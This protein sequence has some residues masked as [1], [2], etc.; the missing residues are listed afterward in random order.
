MR[1]VDFIQD[2]FFSLP[3]Y[4]PEKEDYKLFVFKMLD[5]FLTK[6]N[7]IDRFDDIH[8]SINSIRERQ[9]HLVK[10]LKQA[11]DDYYD[12]KPAEAFKKLANGLNSNVKN[13]SDLLRIRKF[14]TESDFYRIRIYKENF[15]L[16]SDQFFHIPYDM[17]GKVKTQRFSIPGFPSL[18]LGTTVYVCWEEMNRPSLNDFQAVR[19]RNTQEI[20][21]VDLSPPKGANL[22][23]QDYYNFLMIWPLV[24]SSSV[25]VR[26]YEDYFKPEYIIPQLLLQWVRENK[27][28]DGIAYQTTHIDFSKSLSKGEFLNVVL[29]VKENKIRGLCSSLKQKFVMTEATSIQLNQSATS[30]APFFSGNTDNLN[31]KIQEIELV[32]G[33]TFPYDISALGGLEAILLDMETKEI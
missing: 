23:P 17:R 27:K 20:N 15:S 7:E 33:R 2:D 16:P 4:Q 8:F 9:G 19:L 30:G 29:P 24:F 3:K 31:E 14:E 32:K 25:S 12:G 26:N 6:L 22:L 11:I 10:H 1:I 5:K 13:F 18:Y 28:I 21:V